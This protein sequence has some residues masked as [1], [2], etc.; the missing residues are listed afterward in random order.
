[1]IPIIILAIEDPDDQ[2]FIE[3][4][5]IS[6]KELMYSQVRKKLPDEWKCE[7][8]D[9]MQS[10]VEKLVDK[11]STLKPLSVE[12]RVSYIS[13]TC[14]HETYSYLRKAKRTVYVEDEDLAALRDMPSSPEVL[15]L[16]KE[17]R[18]NIYEVFKRLD[19]R[20]RMILEC[21]YI[22]RMPDAEIAKEIGIKPGSVRMALTRA[23]D[24]FREK[25]KEIYK[26][27]V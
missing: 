14:K 23:R 27:E 9:I 22:L 13:T 26:I 15:I 5:Y 20:T 12:Q 17:R 25:Y 11:I 4:L 16:D 1:M 19:E 6:Y 7:T 3:G 21:K 24:K 2:A 18:E 10:V 8:D